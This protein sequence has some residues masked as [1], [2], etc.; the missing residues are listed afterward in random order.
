MIDKARNSEAS[1]ED[2]L[3]RINSL[4][5]I[6]PVDDDRG[7]RW[8]PII[9]DVRQQTLVHCRGVTGIL[10][11]AYP[12]DEF[13]LNWIASK[14]EE[15]ERYRD[16]RARFGTSVHRATEDLD[17]GRVLK[18]R[19]M[20]REMIKALVSYVNFHEDHRPEVLAVEKTVFDTQDRIAGTLDRIVAI[21]KSPLLP[22]R[23]LG[24]PG[25]RS[26]LPR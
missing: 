6:Y 25:G 9:S 21:G 18:T 20:S 12:K 3:E 1:D 23:R 10:G 24:L 26:Q 4:S 17:Q 5:K 19:D 13:L 14:G 8:Y 11:Y 22:A 16:E 7:Q 2:I 15:G